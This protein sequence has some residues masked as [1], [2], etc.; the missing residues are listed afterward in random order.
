MDHGAFSLRFDK[1]L[2]ITDH[3]HRNAFQ[4]WAVCFAC[5]KGI[6]FPSYFMN[7]ML[8][9]TA[10][11]V[12]KPQQ[13]PQRNCSSSRHLCPSP[14]PNRAPGR[15]VGWRHPMSISQIKSDTGR[16]DPQRPWKDGGR[17]QVVWEDEGPRVR[18]KTTDNHW[19]CPNTIDITITN[20]SKWG[21]L[22]DSQCQ[23]PLLKN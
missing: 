9:K 4:K 10:K 18:Q 6:Q 22:H 21:Q 15:L 5:W 19:D 11:K 14:Q 8:P 7:L 23:H 17:A 2:F 16:S 3:Y 13:K 20:G 12:L 1:T